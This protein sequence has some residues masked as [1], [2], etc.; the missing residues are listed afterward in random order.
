MSSAADPL[1]AQ[2]ATVYV[3][4]MADDQHKPGWWQTAPGLMTAVAAMIAAV[5]GLITGLNQAGLL[6][7]TPPA[8]VAQAPAQPPREESGAV[9]PKPSPAPAPARESA[10][11]ST[12]RPARASGGTSRP[13]PAVPAPGPDSTTVDTARTSDST[14]IDTS[15]VAAPADTSPAPADTIVNAP[16]TTT[17]ETP[18]GRIPAGS[19]IELAAATRVCSTTSGPGDQFGATVVAPVTGIGGATVP[20]GATATLEVQQLEAPTFIG[21]SADS[22]TVNG[23]SYALSGASAKVHEREFTAG[24]GRAGVGVGACIP[25][26]GRITLTLRAPLVFGRGR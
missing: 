2:R 12:R 9:S 8:P 7:R 1:L 21:V 14:A 20:V 17:A 11:P 19:T 25:T 15:A 23:R 6:D 22:L 16:A 4:R 24:A 5:T 26:G 3:A 18:S 13:S 10:T